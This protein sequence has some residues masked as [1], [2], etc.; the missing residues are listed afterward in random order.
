M[1]AGIEDIQLHFDA[2]T[3]VI[4]GVGQ[5]A[6]GIDQV[7]VAR[8]FQTDRTRHQPLPGIGRHC[9][10]GRNRR[11]RVGGGSFDPAR[12]LRNDRRQTRSAIVVRNVP[13][14]VKAGRGRNCNRDS[15]RKNTVYSPVFLHHCPDFS[16]TGQNRG[17]VAVRTGNRAAGALAGKFDGSSAILAAALEITVR[18]RH[19]RLDG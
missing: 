16:G 18:R 15:D 19:W 2:K 3:L 17:P 10:N 12:L 7:A 11:D 14:P 9:R 5:P 8:L 13:V 1:L 4:A 6:D